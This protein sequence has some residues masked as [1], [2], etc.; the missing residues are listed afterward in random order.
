MGKAFTVPPGNVQYICRLLAGGHPLVAC[1]RTG[2]TFRYVAAGQIYDGATLNMNHCVLII[3]YGVAHWPGNP[4]D[5]NKAALKNWP[6]HPVT[7]ERGPRVF[8]RAR[9]SYDDRSHPEYSRLA[10]GADFDFW[11]DDVVGSVWGFHI[12]PPDLH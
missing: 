5:H 12:H 1:I 3:G 6:R 10:M 11:V 7:R 4:T 2:R 8:Y 9:G